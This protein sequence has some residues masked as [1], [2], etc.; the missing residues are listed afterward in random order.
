MAVVGFIGLG[1][2]G[3]PMAS[4]LLD[5]GTEMWVWNRSA[6]RAASL[7]EAGARRAAMPAEVT[8]RA[9]IVFSMLRD[10]DAARE[11]Y[12][13]TGGLLTVPAKG[14]LFVEM[15]TL[16]PAMVRALD[17]GARAVGGRFIDC[18]VSGTVA[19]A[20]EGR[21]LGLAGG[22]ATDL[23][24]AQPYLDRLCRRVIHA[25]PVGSGA[26]LKLAVNLPLAVYWVALGDAVSLG[27]AGGLDA[28]VVLEAIS[29]SSAALTVLR[30]KLPAIRTGGSSDAAFDVAAMCKDVA[31]MVEEGALAGV[32]LPSASLAATAYAAALELG[33]GERD[34]VA[35]VTCARDLNAVD[36]AIAEAATALAD[37]TDCP[38]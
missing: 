23:E 4:R 36:D 33:L 21:L 12:S 28:D 3:T 9:E 1:R 31:Y 38:P 16:R 6:A 8:A 5:G 26:V 30:L 13:G 19:P 34:A 10:D 15:G 37:T 27:R 35:V 32:A 17:E 25:G 22:D 20:R 7:I 14:K 11:V 2:M 29:D 18:P 24:R